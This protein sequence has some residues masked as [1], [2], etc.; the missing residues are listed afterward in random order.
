MLKSNLTRAASSRLMTGASAVALLAMIGTTALAQETM[1]TVTVTG[2]RE[3]LEKALD[4]KRTALDASDS[5]MAEDIAKFPDMNVSESLQRIPGVAITREAGEGREIMVRG[6]GAQFTRV[7]INGIEAMATVGSQDVSTSGGGTNRG[8]AFD[9]NVF[10]S[11]LFNKL[12]VH[13]SASASLEEGSLGATVD[14]STAHPFDYA[15]FVFTAS[16]QGGYQ[17]LA[18][19]FNPRAAALISDT[20]AGGKLGALLTVAYAVT[21]TMEAGTSSVRWLNNTNTSSTGSIST[22]YNFGHVNGATSGAD[23]DAANAAF[24][25]RFPR[26]DIV[27][28]KSKRLGITA[29][30][31]WQPDDD[32]LFTVD[33]MYADF[34]QERN[35]YYI[36]APSFSTSGT[37]TGGS[38]VDT[39]T[40]ATMYYR[41]LGIKYQ[42][43]INFDAGDLASKTGVDAVGNATTTLNRAEVIGVGL[44]DEH[45]LDHLDTRFMQVTIDGTHTFSEDFKVHILGGWTESHHRNPVQTTLMADYGCFGTTSSTTGCGAGTASDPFIYDY[46]HGDMPLLNFG[47]VDVTSTSGWFLSNIRERE[48]FAYNS[49]RSA[50]ADFEFDASSEVKFTGGFDFRNYG[51][52]TLELRRSTGVAGS[53]TEASSLSAATRSVPLA[54][55]TSLITLPK[56]GAPA[57]SDTTWF[58]FDFNK[59]ASALQIGDPSVFPMSMDPGYSN[60]GTVR[61]NDFGGWLQMTWDT[62]V[63]GLPF[64]GDVGGRYILTESQSV[65]YS[66]INGTVTPIQG[67]HVYHDFLPALNMV[68]EPWQD[69]LVRFNASYAMSRPNMTSMLPTGSVAVTGSNAG[70]KVGNPSLNPTRSKNLDL[71]FEWYYGK[72]ALF[73]VAGFWK[74]IDTFIQNRQSTGTA[75]ENPFGLESAA[76]VSACGGTGSDWSTIT[77]PYCIANGGANMQWTYTATVNAKGAPLYGTEINWQQPLDFLPKPFDSFGLLGNFTYV[78]ARQSYYSAPSALHPNGQLIMTEDLVNLS[79][80]SYNGTVYY[81][82]GTLQARV[83]GAFRSHYLINSN[84]ASNNNNYGIF[85]KSTFNLDASASYKF[86]EELMFTFDALNLTDQASNIVADKY[87]QRSYQYHKTGPVYYL[88]VKYTY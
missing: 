79:R 68:L 73:S 81:D 26:Y 38:Y 61:E 86:S 57:G 5:I 6:L 83:T 13:K 66:L 15:G 40:S 3:S 46:S 64:R 23:F 11:D 19:S 62:S 45:R 35:E 22:S 42:S 28:T 85:S 49:F 24:K 7:R 52:G 59:A 65:G 82:D 29:S 74:H 58:T 39:N 53:T 71:A 63:Y 80:I 37:S 72:G 34:A 88:G 8:R 43:L 41:T 60:T 47:N 87:A 17:D 84:I 18:G 67:H 30:L 20:F 25:P 12:T 32:T 36:E 76:F 44:R 9:F 14:L 70:A 54:T 27:P 78:Q 56:V 75:A 33:G 10:A 16:A 55:Y 4:L 31:Q 2:F 69:F 48:E 77:A 1:E 50:Q 51:Y 21:N